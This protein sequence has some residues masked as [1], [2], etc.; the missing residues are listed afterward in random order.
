MTSSLPDV[1]REAFERFVTT[2]LT[3][4]DSRGQPITWPLTPFYADGAP[5][6]DV[7]TGLG[8]PKKADDARRTPR[9]SLLFSDPTGSGIESGIQVLVQGAA[10]VDED[11]LAANR[12]R[13]ARES[14]EKLPATKSLHP[15]KFLRGPLDWYYARIYIKVRP[16]RVL[17]WPDGDL[18]RSPEIQDA[19]IDEV[20]SGHVEDP[21]P[22]PSPPAGGD[23]IWDPRIDQL[24]TA[25][26]TAVLS[27]IGPDG[28]PLAV[29][30]PVATDEGERRVRIGAVPAELPL[31]EG[32]ACLT[33]HE[34]APE[35]K[36]QRNFQVRGRL[37][38][39]GGGWALAPR[40]VVGGFNVPK[41][42]IGRNRAFMSGHWRFYKTA[43][44]R[45]KARG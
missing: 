1:A 25:F 7:T 38:P 35:F 44:K 34:H 33:A 23:P 19:R 26:P 27:W 10:I 42:F 16:E 9:V 11:D 29:R 3:T 32:A 36:W 31:A 41:T 12:D 24:G 30:V 43:R 15:P 2:E 5:T 17:I 14:G 37:V 45:M 6:I 40:K 13:Y 20:R 21:E 8:Y 28:L 39:D 22:T 18:S 4:I